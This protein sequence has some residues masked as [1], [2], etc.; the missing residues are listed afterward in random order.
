MSGL[1]IHRVTDNQLMADNVTTSVKF[2]SSME[3]SAH[4]D[5][6]VP[7]KKKERHMRGTTAR[8]P[9]AYASVAPFPFLPAPI[10]ENS[11]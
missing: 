5:E 2:S 1:L 6:N 11:T 9:V 3:T 7:T 4:D 10:Y 8:P